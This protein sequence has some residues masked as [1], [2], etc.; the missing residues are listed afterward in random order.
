MTWPYLPDDFAARIALLLASA[1][2]A[3]GPLRSASR[4]ITARSGFGV[5]LLLARFPQS[6][7][8]IAK[9]Y[10]MPVRPV[11]DEPGI[12]LGE[13]HPEREYHPSGDYELHY[14]TEEAYSATPE[15]S[16]LPAK[17]LVTGLLVLGAIGSG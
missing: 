16:V 14:P 17:S 11:F 7:T 5:A 1:A 4:L 6:Q 8:A 13:A 15:W 10:R 9:G 3:A 12:V 2:A